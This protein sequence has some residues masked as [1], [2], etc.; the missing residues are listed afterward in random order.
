MLSLFAWAHIAKHSLLNCCPFTHTRVGVQLEHP[1]VVAQWAGAVIVVAVGVEDESEVEGNR[2]S[3][4]PLPLPDSAYP[5]DVDGEVD[6]G[7]VK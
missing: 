1:R 6:E 3:P 5:L 7:V 2:P 4:L